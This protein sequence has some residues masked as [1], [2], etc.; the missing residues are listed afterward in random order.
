MVAAYS[1][2]PPLWGPTRSDSLIGCCNLF[3]KNAGEPSK[4]NN[5]YFYGQ[6]LLKAIS[7]NIIQYHI[8][9]FTMVLRVISQGDLKLFLVLR[10]HIKLSNQ[11][12][13]FLTGGHIICL[14][15]WLTFEII[16]TSFCSFIYI[17]HITSPCFISGETHLAD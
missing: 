13:W 12:K 8:T 1:I 5:Y 9:Q 14:I 3:A 15:F 16:I 11:N 4:Y 17:L 2:W 6:L 10:N 7:Y